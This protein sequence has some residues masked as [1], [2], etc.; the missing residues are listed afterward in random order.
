MEFVTVIMIYTSEKDFA[1]VKQNVV[2]KEVCR[3]VA[4]EMRLLD[5]MVS[6]VDPSMGKEPGQEESFSWYGPLCLETLS[7]H[8]Q[9]K[10]EKILGR[11]VLPSY[12]Y[13]R[14]YRTNGHLD[15]HLDRRASEYTVSVCLEKDNTHDWELCVQRRN[16]NVDVFTLEVGDILVYPGRDLVHW[17]N[18][19]FQGKEQVQ[20]FIQY[21]D[22]NG[23]ST[24]L[25]WDGRPKMG[26]EFGS[27]LVEDHNLN[28]EQDLQSK[29][30]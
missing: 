19:R 8:I 2:D 18:G 11:Q 7:L 27:T 3:F 22:A 10:L 20:G 28:R 15:K 26:L 1:F 25:K 5:E 13:G 16:K 12:T 29:I 4:Q 17:R 14:I 23:D 30:S 9:P 21:V 24:D 6:H